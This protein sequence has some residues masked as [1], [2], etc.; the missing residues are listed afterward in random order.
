MDMQ[1]FLYCA[2]LLTSESNVW[3]NAASGIFISEGKVGWMAAAEI[4]EWVELGN[5]QK[6]QRVQRR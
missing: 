2:L 3:L 4:K 6:V 1:G 5:R